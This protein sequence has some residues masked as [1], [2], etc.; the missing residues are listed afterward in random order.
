MVKIFKVLIF[1]AV[2]VVPYNLVAQNKRGCIRNIDFENQEYFLQD[3]LTTGM[4]RFPVKNGRFE[5]PS[6]KPNFPP[7]MFF[8]IDQI[9]YGDLTGDGHDEAIIFAAYGSGSGNHMVSVTY[10]FECKNRQPKLLASLKQSDLQKDRPFPIYFYTD[11]NIIIKNKVLY[12]TY[13]TGE[14]HID[15]NCR[16]TFGYRLKDSKLIPTGTIRKHLATR[17]PS[18]IYCT[19]ARP[20]SRP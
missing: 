20:T 15:P 16:V 17:H 6:E 5:K 19:G 4:E 7:D 1:L 2:I 8:V 3:E 14:S 11:P 13:Y 10:V 18:N 12:L 9:K